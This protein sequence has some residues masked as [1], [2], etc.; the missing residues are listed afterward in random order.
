MLVKVE[1]EVEVSVAVV[2]VAA[3][4]VEVDDAHWNP[5]RE[6]VE[7]RAHRRVGRRARGHGTLA[8]T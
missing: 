2:V 1:V 6:D 3:V 4:K 5:R 8:K 7:K